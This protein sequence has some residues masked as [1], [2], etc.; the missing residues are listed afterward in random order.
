MQPV[1]S[2]TSEIAWEPVAGYPAGTYGK[3]LRRGK[4]GEPQTVLMKLAAGFN[5]PAHSH[6]YVER[7]YVISGG[8]QSQGEQFPAGS[9][10]VI[11]K[12]QDHGPFRSE[13][14]AEVLV[15]WEA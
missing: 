8:Y 14:G 12:H 7:H 1:V 10:R 6:V 15:M 9:Y 3:D 4:D 5:M 2:R 11:P 13:Q